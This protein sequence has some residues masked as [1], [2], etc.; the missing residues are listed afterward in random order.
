MSEHG[1]E[2]IQKQVRIYMGVFAA[3]A[4]L[5]LL[6]V[7]ISY[8]DI[9]VASHVSLALFVAIVKGTLVALFFMHLINERRTIYYVL[10]LVV[11]FFFMVMW[12]PTLWS[13]TDMRTDSVWTRIPVAEA[14]HHGGSLDG[15]GHAAETG[16]GEHH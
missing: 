4:V 6:T 8:L 16:T 5:T 15:D 10:G 13:T 2:H 7:G 9:S 12:V 14:A 1:A 11:V 3:L